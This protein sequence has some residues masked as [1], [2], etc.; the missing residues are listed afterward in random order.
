MLNKWSY[1]TLWI[2]DRNFLSSCSV[3]KGGQRSV[4]VSMEWINIRSLCDR[5]FP[6]IN[7]TMCLCVCACFVWP[8]FKRWCGWRCI[9]E[10]RPHLCRYN[11][12]V[13]MASVLLWNYHNVNRGTLAGWSDL[14]FYKPS[15]EHRK[16]WPLSMSLHHTRLCTSM[17]FSGFFPPDVWTVRFVY[18]HFFFCLF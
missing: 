4:S 9:S 11:G 6:G 3:L 8:W 5:K 10:L 13:V 14:K 12:T 16:P 7:Y 2:H 17:K 1:I 18:M 15:R